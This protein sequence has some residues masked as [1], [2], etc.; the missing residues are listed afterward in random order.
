MDQITAEKHYIKPVKESL[1]DYVDV[2]Q[3]DGT[4]PH[5]SY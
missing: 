1:G 4:P 5:Q 3:D 2:D